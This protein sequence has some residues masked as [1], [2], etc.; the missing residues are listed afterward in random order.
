MPLLLLYIL[1]A[2][3]APGEDSEEEKRLRE[4][5][6]KSRQQMEIVPSPTSTPK[7]T[8]I[9]ATPAHK[10]F[11][12]AEPDEHPKTP[13]NLPHTPRSRPTASVEATPVNVPET[14]NPMTPSPT[15]TPEA[16]A[17]KS[18][19]LEQTPPLV[20][21]PAPTAKKRHGWFLFGKRDDDEI[22]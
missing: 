10:R 7:E 1:A 21:A 14:P 6:L 19:T 8:P 2:S 15:S 4:L 3:F 11:R 20:S 18:P 12:P 17:T 22:V 5:F 13:A 16:E 9:P